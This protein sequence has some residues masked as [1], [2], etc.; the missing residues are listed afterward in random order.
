MMAISSRSVALILFCCLGLTFAWDSDDLEV[1]DVVEEV[2]VNFYE[3]LDVDQ[4]AEPSEIRKAFRRLSLV[5]HPD[6]SDAPDAEIQFRRL[7]AVHEILK[8]P[9]KRAKYDDVLENGLPDWRQAVYYYRRVRKMGLLELAIIL[10]I[11]IT[12]GQYLVAWAAYFEKKYAIEE[13]VSIQSKK[14]Q[15]KQKKGKLADTGTLEVLPEIV[16]SLPK[17]TMNC[18][19]PVQIVRLIWFLIV[20]AGPLTKT[21]IK[22][23]LEERKRRQEEEAAMKEE[24][25]EVEKVVAPRERGPRRRKG[26][27]VPE[28]KDNGT[29]SPAE[30][31]RK[32]ENKPTPKSPP[33][34]SGGL[35]T[36]DDLADLI[37][38]MKKFPLGTQERWEKIGDAMRRPPSEVAH[39]AHKMKDDGFK[40]L[41]KQEEEN[42]IVEEPKKVKTKGGKTGEDVEEGVWSQVQQKALE[43]ALANFPKSSASDRWDKIAKCVPGKN[44]E[45][46]K[47]RYKYLV[48]AV[49][50]KKKRDT[51]EDNE[52]SS[53]VI[54]ES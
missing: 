51:S 26:F 47:L 3:L 40:P 34:L 14:L 19:L 32:A 52:E 43:A 36:D 35:W 49:K 18:I 27:T 48:E 31:K 5:L 44:K 46:C 21:W 39:M 4:K 11:I 6:K 1:F 42:E 28:L 7:V 24:L 41:P 17:P 23:Y 8:D 25:A 50:K 13:Y 2:G 22:E 29:A 37:R 12:I 16:K 45:E 9:G 54:E 10:F 20:D 30:N 38:L 15:K 53:S 33:V